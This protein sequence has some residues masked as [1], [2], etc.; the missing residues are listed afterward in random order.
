M[1]KILNRIVIFLFTAIIFITCNS[2]KNGLLNKLHQFDIS[3]SS[4]LTVDP[5]E[6]FEMDWHKIIIL[7]EYQVLSEYVD[8]NYYKCSNIQC[9]DAENVLV[10]LSEN[11]CIQVY[12]T[13]WIEVNYRWQGFPAKPIVIDR[14]DNIKLKIVKPS[15]ADGLYIIEKLQ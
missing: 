8:L 2:D 12:E 6:F 14:N 11:R 13:N 9:P 15:G 1:R 5:T 3:E 7:N 4:S 10:L